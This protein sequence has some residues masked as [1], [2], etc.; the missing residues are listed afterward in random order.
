MVG[1]IG[2]GGGGTA[3]YIA[4]KAGAERLWCGTL[5][6]RDGREIHAELA[7]I[8]AVR[9]E[10]ADPIQHIILSLPPGEKLTSQPDE[11]D[12]H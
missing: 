5:G 8:T 2:A 4:G 10:A 7:R 3:H 9:P 6:G 12:Q 1:R 11:D